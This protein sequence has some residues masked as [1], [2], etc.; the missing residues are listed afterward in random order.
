MLTKAGLKKKYQ[1][2]HSDLEAR[3]YKKHELTK[4]E[5]DQLHGELWNNYDTEMLA[6][7]YKQ[8]PVLAR[9][10]ESELDT[11]KARI[12]SLENLDKSAI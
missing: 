12:A 5:F 2:L 3:Y 8:P 4:E 1:K 9:N 6:S 7:G 10:L 11:L